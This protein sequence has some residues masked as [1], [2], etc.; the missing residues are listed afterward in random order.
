MGKL[1]F[2]YTL[3]SVQTIDSETQPQIR[4][5]THFSGWPPHQRD[6]H[7]RAVPCVQGR[8]HARLCPSGSVAREGDGC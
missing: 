4:L 1:H 8:R 5:T 3:S 2:I 6:H 7:H